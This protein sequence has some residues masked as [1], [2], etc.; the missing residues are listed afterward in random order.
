MKIDGQLVPTEPSVSGLLS[1]PNPTQST[2]IELIQSHTNLERLGYTLTIL[3]LMAL[4]IYAK[5]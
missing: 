1:Y 5:I 4:F 3:T 2:N